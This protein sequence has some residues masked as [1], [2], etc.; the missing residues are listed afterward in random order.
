M[1]IAYV[2]IHIILIL[3]MDEKKQVWLWPINILHLL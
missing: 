2:V 1:K 3:W